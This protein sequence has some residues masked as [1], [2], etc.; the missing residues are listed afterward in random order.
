MIERKL[1]DPICGAIC[2]LSMSEKCIENCAPQGEMEMLEVRDELTIDRMPSY[3]IR[4]DI[5][6][7]A[8]FRL[9]EAYTKKAVDFIQGHQE[10][11]RGHSSGIPRRPFPHGQRHSEDPQSMPSPVVPSDTS[12]EL[13]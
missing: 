12:D 8:R 10:V 3:E 4:E 1:P 11:P 2:R 9:Q 6:W 5:P 7:K 13:R